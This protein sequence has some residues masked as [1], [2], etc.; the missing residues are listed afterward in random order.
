MATQRLTFGEWMPDQPAITG[1]LTEAKNVVSQAVGYGPLPQPVAIAQGAG[2]NLKTLYATKNGLGVTQLFAGG[3]SKVFTASNLGAFTDVS[4]TSYATAEVDRMRFTQFGSVVI[5]ANNAD[6]LQGFNLD[7]S[8]AFADLSASAPVAKYVTIVRDFVVCANTLE[9][10]TRYPNRVRWSGINDETEWIYSQSTQADYQD[11]PD[12]G[13][14]VGIT[15][16]EFGLVF[17]EKAIHRMSYVGTP[18]VFQFDNIS[19]GTGCLTEN[20]IVQWQGLSFFLS[21]DGFYMCDGQSVK[22][23]GAEKVDRWFFD[24]CDLTRF[25]QMS[26]SIDPVRK[27]VIWNFVS[28]GSLRKLLIY[29]FKTGKWTNAEALTD[30]IASAST[31]SV[32]LE[33][34]DSISASLDDLGPSLDASSFIGGQNFMGGLKEDD[35]YAF[36]GLPRT[37]EIITGDV[38][39]GAQSVVTLAKPQVDMGSATVSVGSRIRLGD[40][41]TFSTPVAASSENRVPLRSSGR[42]HRFKINPTGDNW[43]NAVSLDVDIVPQGGR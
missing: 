36:T 28:S 19:R 17:L 1:A 42:Y 14:V 32:T 33:Q 24:N 31:G 5:F 4:G 15:G 21:D 26:A 7:S 16:G 30:Y 11:I 12:G 25:D 39:V 6:K 23:I 40:E 35:I 20:S 2:E 34:L 37:G 22:P 41:L 8:G 29:N 27:L 3:T 38:D 18:F 43:S 13:N 10:T 9:V